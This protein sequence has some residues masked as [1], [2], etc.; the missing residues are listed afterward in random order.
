MLIPQPH[1]M[2]GH[3]QEDRKRVATQWPCYLQGPSRAWDQGLLIGISQSFHLQR[4]RTGEHSGVRS[5]LH[6]FPADAIP[7]PWAQQSFPTP[8]LGWQHLCTR[9]FSPAVQEEINCHCTSKLISD[10]K[11]RRKSS[12]RPDEEARLIFLAVEACSCI[13]HG[14]KIGKQALESRASTLGRWWTTWQI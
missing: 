3:E 11:Y 4:S 12:E 7:P 1:H 10:H 6:L 5:M 2:T 13:A 14:S 9:L 8:T